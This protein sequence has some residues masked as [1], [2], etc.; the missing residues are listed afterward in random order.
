M[1]KIAF[2]FMSRALFLLSFIVIPIQAIVGGIEAA[3]AS[4]I[5][6][7]Y[8]KSEFG[9]YQFSCGGVLISPNK[10]LTA[11]NCVD[12]RSLSDLKIGYGSLD[13]DSEPT[14]SHLSEITIHPDY[15]PLTLSANIAVLT[16]RD[17]FSAPSYAP[18]AQQPSIRTGDS[19]TLYGWG[20]T[21]LEKIK[22]PTKLHKVEVQAL[23][24]IACV[25]EHLDLGSGQFCDTSTSG[26]GSCF[27]DHG[28]P[29]LD[30]SGT[31]VGIISGRQ[32]CGLAKSELITDVAHYYTWIISH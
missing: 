3:Q 25:S 22:L 23:D 26:K 10:I 17:V 32:N 19:L 31:V 4:H 16:L 11:A 29:A 24:T 20:R 6:A 2:S 18:L 9:F 28:G 27:G 8:A 5:G 13:R 15:D 7:L 1:M 14:T 30:S 21:S 12:G